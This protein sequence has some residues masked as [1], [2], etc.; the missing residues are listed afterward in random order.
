MTFTKSVGK[1][2][3]VRIL[4]ALEHFLQIMN[5]YTNMLHTKCKS[6]ALL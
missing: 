3:V 5:F 6:L 2:T 4:L 1:N